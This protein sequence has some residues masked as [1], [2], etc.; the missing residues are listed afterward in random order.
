MQ[1]FKREYII[2]RDKEK[3]IC[4]D[5]IRGLILFKMISTNNYFSEGVILDLDAPITK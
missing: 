3:R 4:I 1:N 5:G 2:V